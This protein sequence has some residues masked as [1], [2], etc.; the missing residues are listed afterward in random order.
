MDV[1]LDTSFIVSLIIKTEKTEKVRRFFTETGLDFA[2]SV[3]VYEESLYTGLRIIAEKRLDIKNA[4][5]L[6]DFVRKNG[7]EFAADFMSALHET[8]DEIKVL[9]DSGDMDSN[10]APGHL[11]PLP[12]RRGAFHLCRGSEHQKQNQDERYLTAQTY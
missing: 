5:K 11:P 4:Y 9:R 2:A 6:R 10:S 8:F 3:A 1:F 12:H 7:Y